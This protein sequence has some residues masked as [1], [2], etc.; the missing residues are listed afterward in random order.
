MKVTVSRDAMSWVLTFN[1]IS[2]ETDK[3]I[4]RA[5]KYYTDS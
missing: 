5:Q 2:E 4:F 3:S 1:N